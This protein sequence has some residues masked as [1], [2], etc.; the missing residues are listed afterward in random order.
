MKERVIRVDA[1]CRVE[2]EGALRVRLKGEQVETVELRLFEPPRFF[3]AFL[4]GKSLLEAP[5]IVARICGICPVAYQMSSVHALEKLCGVRVP[6][7]VRELRRLFYCGEWIESHALHVFMLHAPDF[8]G[9]ADGLEMARDHRALVERGLRLKKTGNAIVALLG[10]REIH[11][12]S[13]RVGGFY[14]APA[15]DA[16][17]GL[18]PS[19]EWAREAAAETLRWSAALDFPD[20]EPDYELVSLR[21]PD[22]YPMNEGR[23]VSSRGLDCEA[24]DFNRRFEERQVPHSTALQALRRGGGTY[25]LGPL[26]R[27]NLNFDRL[28]AAIREACRSLGVAPPLANPFKS[29]A[30]RAAELWLACEEALRLARSYREPARAFAEVPP[31][32]GEGHAATEAPRGLLYH[33]YR[34]DA[35]GL[36]TDVQIVPPT[37]QNQARIEADLRELLPGLLRLPDEELQARCE[38]AIRNYDPCISCAAHFLRLSVERA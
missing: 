20:F 33:R 38:R 3:E 24:E 6:E 15:R 34:T 13:A 25:L 32:A 4:R 5:D 35:G 8:L 30:A 23:I 31:R 10:G 29:I 14:R 7:G 9:Y 27:F 22:E 1:L 37:S 21:H 28:P 16:L 18:I 17:R 36:L 19:L 11:P 2:G 12:V 26:A